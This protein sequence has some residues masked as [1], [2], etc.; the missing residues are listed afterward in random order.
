[1]HPALRT[2]QVVNAGLDFRHRQRELIQAMDAGTPAVG[3]CWPHHALHERAREL[4]CD[5]LLSPNW[6]NETFSSNAPW[7][8]PEWLAR[9]R[10]GRAWQALRADTADARPLWRQFL[11]RAVLPWLP[12]QA[13][14]AVHRQWHGEPHD[15]LA[16]SALNPEWLA[17]TGLLE[18][19]RRKQGEPG[20]HH[21]RSRRQFW[22][23]VMAEDGQD[24][25]E[26]SQGMEILYG[27]PLRDPAAY[28]PLVEFCFGL[29]TDLFRHDGQTR[30]LAREMARG[31]LPEELRTR[32]T[33][34]EH[35]PDWHARLKPHAGS[36]L[37]EIDAMG[38]DGDVS[39]MLD[40]PRLR[41]LVAVLPDTDP[42]DHAARLAYVVALPIAVAAARFIAYGKG[43]NDF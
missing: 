28:R 18:Q 8:L 26:Y 38:A 37:A 40:L 20:R 30:W 41:R 9:G 11:A 1:M 12:D 3:L 10:W 36:I 14:Q 31:R 16:G 32:E 43:R 33:Q 6:G 24:R 15:P 4:G 29:P 17:R 7:A 5:V 39:A 27:I 23:S 35:H 2:E 25:E 13:W 34:G 42:A 22:R 19:V 21:Y